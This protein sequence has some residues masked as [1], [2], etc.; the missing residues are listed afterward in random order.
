MDDCIF[1]KIINGEI[2]ADI[3]Y[4]DQDVMAFK[5]IRPVAPNHLLF[6]PKKH[7][8]TLSDLTKE[9]GHLM[10]NLSLAV[11]N[12]AQKKGLESYRIVCNC[13]EDAGQTVFHIHFHLLAGRKFQ[14][15]P[16]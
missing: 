9:D 12:V 11:A 4:E 10:A 15:P 7:I 8:P 6:I 13:N 1:C 3:V 14:W 5:D 16:G 2:P